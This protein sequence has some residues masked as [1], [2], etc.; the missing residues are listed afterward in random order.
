MF[1]AICIKKCDTFRKGEVV[2]VWQGFGTS[3]HFY[4][5]L[6]FG[7]NMEQ[8]RFE[9]HFMVFRNYYIVEKP[10]VKKRFRKPQ[11]S[12]LK[13]E[14]KDI[15]DALLV[16]LYNYIFSYI[17]LTR[18]ISPELIFTFNYSIISTLE[19]LEFLYTV[20]PELKFLDA[21]KDAEQVFLGI[22][23]TALSIELD[24]LPKSEDYHE[25]YENFKQEN[26]ILGKFFEELNKKT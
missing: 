5:G 7:L 13:V 25:L 23:K 2:K 4:K 3:I 8:K 22:Y 17:E 12:F 20:L 26:Q 10:P 1:R 14:F 9:E 21:I 15:S 11:R 16:D 24:A 19:K 18:Q 6:K